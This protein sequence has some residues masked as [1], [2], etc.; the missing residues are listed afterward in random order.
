MKIKFEAEVEEAIEIVVE[1]P[2][3]TQEYAMN[4]LVIFN[5]AREYNTQFLSVRNSRGNKVFVTC[6]EKNVEN[7]REFLSCYGNIVEERKVLYACPVSVPS[8]A[9]DKIFDQIIDGTYY[10]IIAGEAEIE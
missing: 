6:R 8:K 1:L 9:L 10:D 7:M 3:S 4:F 5:N 2:K